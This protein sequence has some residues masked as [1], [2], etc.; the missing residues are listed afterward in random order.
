MLEKSFMDELLETTLHRA[1]AGWVEFKGDAMVQTIQKEYGLD[2]GSAESQLGG[3]MSSRGGALERKVHDSGR[4]Q[5]SKLRTA[6]STTHYLVAV[7][8]DAAVRAASP[9]AAALLW[10]E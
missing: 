3:W 4:P 7:L 1:H 9:Q 10:P 8:P 6:A 5:G 2:E